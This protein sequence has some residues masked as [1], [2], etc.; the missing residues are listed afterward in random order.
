MMRLIICFTVACVIMGASVLGQQPTATPV[1]SGEKI[2]VNVDQL[3]PELVAQI[4][5]N[6]RL[7]SASKYV[8]W[9]HEIGVAF[10]EGLSAITK[11]AADFSETDLGRFAMFLIAWKVL[12]EDVFSIGENGVRWIFW[13]ATFSLMSLALLWSYRKNCIPR[14]VLIEVTKEPGLFGKH[15]KKWEI[16][17]PQADVKESDEFGKP[18]T[19]EIWMFCHGVVLVILILVSG[20]ASCPGSN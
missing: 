11:H 2:L 8:K 16:Y 7:E 18:W 3:P 17:I 10:D 13:I 9:G 15:H 5:T 19:R 20:L 4:K 1:T 14:R 6:Q 12:A